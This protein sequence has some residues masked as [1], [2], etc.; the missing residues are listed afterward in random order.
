MHILGHSHS[1]GST[2][3]DNRAIQLRT[4]NDFSEL[5]TD[6]RALQARGVCTFYQTYEWCQAWQSSIGLARG[7]E[8]CVIAGYY[9]QKLIFILPVAVQKT[10]GARVLKWIGTGAMTY[11]MG[12]YC[13]DHF[14]QSSDLSDLWPQILDVIGG[15]DG[16]HL[17]RQP[18]NWQGFINPLQFLFTVKSANS[19]YSMALNSDFET[20]YQ[21]K[22]SSSSRRGNRKRDKKLFAS[23]DVQFGLPHTIC[24]S[25]TLLETMQQQQVDRLSRRGIKGLESK[26]ISAF[27]SAL[28]GLSYQSQNPLLLAYH[29]TVDG[30]IAAVMLGASF[31]NTYWALVS[32]LTGS[33]QLQRFSPGDYALRKTISALCENGYASFDF[34]AGESDYKNHWADGSIDLN[35]TVRITNYKGIV[36]GVSRLATSIAKRF[37]KNNKLAFATLSKMRALVFGGNQT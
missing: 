27:L 13:R 8:P 12:L 10:R 25:Q 16:V 30:E 14:N 24:Q 4:F 22:R 3:V 23:G 26:E 15:V 1:K 32:S 19:S 2:L 34:S 36:W 7:F 11:G 31:K 37:L 28:N 21:L 17:V 29:L 5:E 35:E 9:Q 18:Y 33:T 6:W 20:L